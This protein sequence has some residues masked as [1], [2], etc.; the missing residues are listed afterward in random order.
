MKVTDGDTFA[1][2]TSLVKHISYVRKSYEITEAKFV[3][4]FIMAAN[5]SLQ[6]PIT[7]IK[8]LKQEKN[9]KD[10]FENE[11]LK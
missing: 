2:I 4:D 7:Y 5:R 6:S 10:P 8:N 3:S 11:F 9:D 1:C